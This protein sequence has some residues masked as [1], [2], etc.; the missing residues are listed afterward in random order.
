MELP[1]DRDALAGIREVEEGRLDALVEGD[2]E[3]VAEC[4][5]PRLTYVHSTG[6][7]D[8]K[9]SLL[10][11]LASGTTLYHSVE[12]RIESA[13]P[14]AGHRLYPEVVVAAG[15]MRLELGGTG[16]T[17]NIHTVTTTVWLCGPDGW[18]MLAFHATPQPS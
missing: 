14:A 10:Q 18:R 17:R 9:E 12:H 11:L 3:A 13:V 5:D 1:L 6:R 4:L 7:R 2:I 15:T 8:N 16:G